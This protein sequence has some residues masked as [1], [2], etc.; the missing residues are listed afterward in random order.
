MLALPTRTRLASHRSRTGRASDWPPITCL[1]CGTPVVPD[2]GKIEQG[3]YYATV[4]CTG[5]T[6]LV[7]M[8]H[9]DALHAVQEQMRT[10]L[11]SARPN[12]PVVLGRWARWR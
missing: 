7:P 11:V 5:C 9:T 2:P 8:T 1:V 3:P 10:Q 6:A 12:R 4:P